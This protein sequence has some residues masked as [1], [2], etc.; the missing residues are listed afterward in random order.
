M[1]R[2]GLDIGSTTIKCVVIGEDNKILFSSYERHMAHIQETA[3]RLLSE[4]ASRFG[5][6][7]MLLSVSGSAG[8]GIAESLGLPFAQEVYAAGSAVKTLYPG[9]D[10]VIELGGEDAKILFLSGGT[11]VRMNGTCAGGTG[12]FID[13]MA[14]LMN[15]DMS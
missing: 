3:S 6:E 14:A 8:M 10:A 5:N 7:T 4:V 11:E 12:A 1:K 15:V 13:Q 9:T 2:A